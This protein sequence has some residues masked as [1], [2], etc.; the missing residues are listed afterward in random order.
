MLE[1]NKIVS[2]SSNEMNKSGF[3][4][5]INKINKKNKKKKKMRKSNII[6]IITNRYSNNK[7]QLNQPTEIIPIKDSLLEQDKKAYKIVT[8]TLPD[9]LKEVVITKK[10]KIQKNK[11]KIDVMN[12]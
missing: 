2:L 8:L 5:R 12:S 9:P 3:L 6:S 11:F 4:K 10:E 1:E 7:K